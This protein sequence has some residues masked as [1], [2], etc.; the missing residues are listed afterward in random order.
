MRSFLCVLLKPTAFENY[1]RKINFH[2]DPS[3]SFPTLCNALIETLHAKIVNII[4]S[5]VAQN[6]ISFKT[7]R[8]Q[9]T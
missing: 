8:S 4:I 9:L 7:Y 1:L 6:Q 2:C 5:Y 3:F